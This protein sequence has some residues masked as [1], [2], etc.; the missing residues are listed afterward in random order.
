VV[1]I[2]LTLDAAHNLE[3]L[4]K[5]LSRIADVEIKTGKAIVTIVGD[6]RRSSEILQR[7]FGTCVLLGIQI[8]MVS[9]GASKVNISFI[10][11]GGQAAEVVA[12]LH[13][14]FFEPL[15]KEV[16]A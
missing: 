12:A 5:D 2:S 11:D 4:R 14:C 9:Q 8:Q 16:V 1:S 13:Q 3:K 7:A 15:N 10:V 6:V